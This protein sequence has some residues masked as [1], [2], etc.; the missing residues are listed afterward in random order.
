MTDRTP[1]TL[2]PDLSGLENQPKLA[3][4]L[5]EK[6]QE[7]STYDES[8]LSPEDREEIETFSRQIDIRD[9]AMVLTYGAAA[10]K[11]M[12]DFSQ[13]ALDRVRTKDMGQVGGML[14]DLVTEIKG[15]DPN[16]QRRGL[17]GRSRAKLAQLKAKYDKAEANVDKIVGALEDHQITLM[18]DIATFDQMYQLNLDYY[19]Q[20]TMYIIAGKKRLEDVRANE[21]EPLRQK[22][23]ETGLPEDAQAYND[24]A[25]LCNRFEKRLYD[26][27]L[28]R[29]ISVQMGPQ[30]RM[31]Q[32]NDALMA[33]KIQTS[34]INTIP[35]WKS[36]MV[37]A[38]GIENAR[39]ATEAQRAVT[40]TTNQ[41]LKR[42]AEL[43]RTG[44]ADAA[45]ESERGIVEIETL[46]HTSSEL[47]AT[48]DDVI[49]I[50]TEGREKRAA[51]E[52]ELAK[53][54]GDLKTKLLEL[55]G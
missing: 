17:F 55:R 7:L 52:T 23:I 35:L 42:N 6:K 38:L 9:S 3:L 33:E 32:N 12:A 51:A 20:L 43:L 19:K 27:E 31:L 39:R 22:A 29:A 37:L 41:L 34:V 45:K 11:N 15:F 28:T 13:G 21:L 30:I 26:L 4:D 50:Q 44:T 24:L 16:G 25:E 53:I 2:T 48:L 46:Q 54:E 14:T 40:D 36:Q 1:L 5:P 47:I 18:K 8:L 49:R 10:Q